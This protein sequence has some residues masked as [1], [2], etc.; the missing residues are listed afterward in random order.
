MS[1]DIQVR[2]VIAIVDDDPS[3]RR[4]MARLM[5]SYGM[6][7]ATFASA[8][9]YLAA[10]NS[11]RAACAVIDLAMTGMSGLELCELLAEA[12]GP[13]VIIISSKGNAAIEERAARCGATLLLKPIESELL[14]AAIGR[15]LGTDHGPVNSE[16]P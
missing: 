8:E 1:G 13:P 7:V 16:P 10:A 14:L 12:G 5:R 6:S 2:P 15:A 3:V 4:A 11:L 9:E